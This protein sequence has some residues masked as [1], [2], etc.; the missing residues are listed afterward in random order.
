VAVE[1]RSADRLGAVEAEGPAVMVLRQERRN[2]IL[3]SHI[4]H[5]KPLR[6]HFWL[7]KMDRTLISPF[8]PDSVNLNYRAA[9]YIKS[10]KNLYVL[11]IIE[12]EPEGKPLPKKITSYAI[13]G[14][15]IGF[16]V[17]VI[18]NKFTGYRAD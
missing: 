12:S 13:T 16:E 17:S 14:P 9:G 6:L 5:R 3:S 10:N 1:V 7:H 2:P 15:G 18:F 11:F 8:S 4:Q